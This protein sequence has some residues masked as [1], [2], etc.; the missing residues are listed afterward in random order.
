M[1]NPTIVEPSETK[2]TISNEDVAV[3]MELNV[4]IPQLWRSHK[5]SKFEVKRTKTELARVRRDLS[6]GLHGMKALLARTGRGGM[7][8]AFLREKK[9][10]RATA[11]RYVA[12]YEASQ[13]DGKEKRLSEAFEEPIHVQIYRLVQRIE[14]Q[15]LRVLK[16]SADV[17]MFVGAVLDKLPEAHFDV[18]GNII[19]IYDTPKGQAV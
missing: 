2:A 3:E 16:T 8:A 5:E 19:E 7:W 10:P 4:L 15:L 17:S 1:N 11:D 12:A 14:P 18:F 9:I 6:E 13:W